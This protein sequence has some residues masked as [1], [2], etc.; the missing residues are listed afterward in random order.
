MSYQIKQWNQP[1]E[2]ME[3]SNRNPEVLEMHAVPSNSRPDMA[4]LVKKLEVLTKPFEQ[5]DVAADTTT[6]WVC[7]CENF[8][9]E[10]W[11]SDGSI[12]DLET[13]PQCR[14]CNEL[15]PI[16]AKDDESQSELPSNP[17]NK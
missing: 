6:V 12:P 14:H 15:K 10:R 3:N 5:A 13:L 17:V 11:P 8:Q 2:D 7:S 4:H 1:L 9:Y 16:K